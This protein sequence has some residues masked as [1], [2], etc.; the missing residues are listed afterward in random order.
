MQQ[1]FSVDNAELG[2]AV[3]CLQKHQH[4]RGIFSG[5]LWK[6]LSTQVCTWC[7]KY[8][9]Y[10]GAQAH[11]IADKPDPRTVIGSSSLKPPPWCHFAFPGMLTAISTKTSI[12]LMYCE[13]ERKQAN[14][15]ERPQSAFILHCW[16]NLKLL[17]GIS[18]FFLMLVTIYCISTQTESLHKRTC[19]IV[20]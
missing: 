6:F 18:L 16:K 14:V 9:S 1:L 13:E 3:L 7:S 5:Y 20:L 12:T 2:G 15:L 19:F 10:M 17:I 4:L 11:N 8:P